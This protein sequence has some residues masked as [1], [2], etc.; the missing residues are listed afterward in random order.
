MKL[1]S[2]TYKKCTSLNLGCKIYYEY[3]YSKCGAEGFAFVLQN[4]NNNATGLSGSGLGYEKIKDALAVEF[5]FQ[6]TTSKNDPYS[7]QEYHISVIAKKGLAS[8]AEDD[9]IV[10]NYSPTNF[11]TPSKS[12]VTSQFFFFHQYFYIFLRENFK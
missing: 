7:N 8:A 2:K 5:D 3:T 4:S 10:N 12:K 9:S 11:F 1:I 6:Q